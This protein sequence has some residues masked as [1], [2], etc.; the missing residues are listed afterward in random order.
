[1]SD[2]TLM[3]RFRYWFD[4][5]MSRG[6]PA[7]IAWLGVLTAIIIA[8]FSVVIIATSLT[9]TDGG[10][11]PDVWHQI[12]DTATTALSF[13]AFDGTSWWWVLTM[14][15]L[16]LAGLF[17]VSTF[18]GL[19]VTGFETKMDELRAGRSLV[20]ENGH[21]LILGWS[22]AVHTIVSE[23]VIANESER[24][25]AVVVLADRERPE[26][27]EELR[28]KV[29]DTGSTRV[30]CRSGSPIDPADIAIANPDGARSIIVLA[31]DA[32]DPDAETIKTLLALVHGPDR[33]KSKYHI[34]AEIEDEKNL[35]VARIAGGDEVTLVSKAKTISRLMVHASR[36]SGI[37]L[38][39][40]E[41]F[42]FGG[43]EIY[44]REDP[45]LVGKTY[46]DALFA[47]E[48]CSVIGIASGGKTKLNPP[49]VTPIGAGD[50]VV[51]VATDDSVLMNASPLAGQVDTS[52]LA[53]ANGSTPP[54]SKVLMLGWNA[55]AHI[56]LDELDSY[57]QPGS[58]VSVIADADEAKE[59]L[60]ENGHYANLAV[61][62]RAGDITDRQLLD[63][64]DLPSYDSMLLLSE[65]DGDGDP[66]RADARTLVTLLHLRDIE[67]KTGHRVPIVSEMLDDR[68]RELAQV[69]KVDD[70]IVS[71]KIV[72][73][74]LAQVS[75]NPALGPL[76]E[77]LLGAEGSE[78]HVKPVERY[79]T[80]EAS[81]AS[82]VEAAKRLGE[83]AI[84]YRSHE[85][86]DDPSKS[87]GVT[88]NPPKSTRFAGAAG[89][90]VILLAEDE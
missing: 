89:D 18:V 19:L 10:K 22:E 20:L 9:P 87:F 81:F 21:T 77:D 49:A 63:A 25:S 42:D 78:L 2:P 73:L 69:T 41:L 74:I 51:A 28:G 32:D 86:R 13:D 52:V 60:S 35:E 54:T 7:M 12:Y 24:R 33:K 38:A 67:G 58:S 59:A 1:M 48:D 53:A 55:R 11:R 23:L 5:T 27:E 37:A 90:R 72:S 79:V 8:V 47:Y 15:L 68:N 44:F 84:G 16:G 4:N 70:V 45:A 14:F 64:I 71:E 82:I 75:Q 43:D 34:V 65:S 50:A 61:E 40:T 62:L 29:G 66:Q 76:F 56:L 36:Q 85:L 3:Q 31:S 39:Y 26:M 17:I 46:G 57:S 83:T 30:V 6:T 88:V 80:G